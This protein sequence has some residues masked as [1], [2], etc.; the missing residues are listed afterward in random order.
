MWANAAFQYIVIG[1]TS[2]LLT[3]SSTGRESLTL[4]GGQSCPTCIVDY[5]TR[6][7]VAV[8]IAEGSPEAR[9]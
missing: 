6:P 3:S 4:L 7:V 8:L 5:E 9:S 2:G 1:Q